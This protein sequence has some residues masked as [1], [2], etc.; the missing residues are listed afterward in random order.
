MFALPPVAKI[1]VGGTDTSKSELQFFRPSTETQERNYSCKI[2]PIFQITTDQMG[3]KMGSHWRWNCPSQGQTSPAAPEPKGPLAFPA[4]VSAQVTNQVQG[5]TQEHRK[6]QKETG[7][8]PSS[9][10]GPKSFQET[11]TKANL[12]PRTPPLELR[13]KW[14]PGSSWWVEAAG[15]DYWGR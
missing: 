2:F 5:P 13:L 4:P 11:A 10:K 8:K 9:K 6:E 15:E 3:M 1:H 7:P 12:K 14:A